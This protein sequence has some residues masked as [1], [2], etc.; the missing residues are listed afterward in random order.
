MQFVFE[1]ITQIGTGLALSPNT[2]LWLSLVGLDPTAFSAG[3]GCRMLF[4]PTLNHLQ[5]IR[6]TL[7]VILLILRAGCS[8]RR[9]EFP[10]HFL[11]CSLPVVCS[12]LQIFLLSFRSRL[13]QGKTR[14]SPPAEKSLVNSG[15]TL[16]HVSR[17]GGD[18]PK[19]VSGDHAGRHFHC[20]FKEGGPLCRGSTHHRFGQTG[21]R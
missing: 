18:L 4:V 21:P 14:Q 11:Q 19:Q 16:Y 1:L 10:C 8:C 20:P 2:S 3:C 17:R 12:F 6:K 7:N 15:S 13:R 5:Y 9:W